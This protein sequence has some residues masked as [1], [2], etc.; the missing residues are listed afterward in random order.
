MKLAILFKLSLM[1][2]IVAIT[3]KFILSCALQLMSQFE[4]YLLKKY[5]SYIKVGR[6]FQY[7]VVNSSY[8]RTAVSNLRFKL[9]SLSFTQY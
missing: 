5:F 8:Q 3:L 7:S 6:I 4:Q 1:L 9:N 2:I